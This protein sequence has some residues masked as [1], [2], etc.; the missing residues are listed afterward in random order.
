MQRLLDQGIATRRGIM[1]AHEEP[2]YGTSQPREPLCSSETA[3]RRSV[4]LPL[5][6]GMSDQEQ[7]AVIEGLLAPLQACVD[8]AEAQML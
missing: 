1:L 7:E 2:A 3:S 6:P 4:L 8:S 5:Y